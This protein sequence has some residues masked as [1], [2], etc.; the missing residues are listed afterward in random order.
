MLTENPDAGVRRA[1]R[2]PARVGSSAATEIINE[3]KSDWVPPYKAP[4]Y[5]FSE[6]YIR[7]AREWADAFQTEV[8]VSIKIFKAEG[9]SETE[10]RSPGRVGEWSFGRSTKAPHAWIT[11]M[12]IRT[13]IEPGL[14][15]VMPIMP[16]DG[17]RDPRFF[18]RFDRWLIVDHTKEILNAPEWD[19]GCGVYKMPL[20]QKLAAQ[21]HRELLRQLFWSWEWRLVQAIK[22]GDA[23]IM[24]RKHS[25]LA[26]FERITW[27]QW[28]YFH[29]DEHEELPLLEDPKWGDP[30]PA[31]RSEGLPWTATGP[32][33]EKLYDIHIAPGLNDRNRE[34]TPE[35]YC[36]E[37]LK[38]LSCDYPDLPP[39][40]RDALGKEA[41]SKFP[42]LSFNA[43]LRCWAQ[44]ASQNRDWSLPGALSEIAAEIAAADIDHSAIFLSRRK[45]KRMS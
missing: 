27:N 30:R 19:A 1:T 43:F 4:F 15:S 11:A 40:P 42:G 2:K 16:G 3:P 29:L 7:S 18:F 32:G 37:W 31:D 26:P 36:L 9:I 41:I 39:R 44:V 21:W 23:Y 5:C 33:G 28:H 8:K 34:K 14:V 25:V 35:E 22:F 13:D 6:G 24:A 10:H 45:V 20:D 38:Q 12:G 17:D